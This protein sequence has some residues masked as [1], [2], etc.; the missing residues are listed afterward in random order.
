MTI[1][2]TDRIKK[3]LRRMPFI[4]YIYDLVNSILTLSETGGTHTATGAEDI[5]YIE[6][7][8]LGVMK[9]RHMYVNLDNMQAGDTTIIREYYRIK[10][11]GNLE[12]LD[13][14]SYANADGGLPNNRVLIL[15]ELSDT[16]FGFKVTLEQT[17]GVMRDYDWELTEEA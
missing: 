9:P 12:L 13:Y 2:F 10:S 3:I 16:R 7:S 1:A 4:D 6:N 17:A 15:V 14:N 5:L 8:P 11:G